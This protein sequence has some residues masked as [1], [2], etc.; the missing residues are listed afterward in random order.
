MQQTNPDLQERTSAF[1]LSPPSNGTETKQE[2]KS[3]VDGCYGGCLAML[4]IVVTLIA[5]FWVLIPLLDRFGISVMAGGTYS[6]VHAIITIVLVVVA[7]VYAYL[8]WKQ[9]TIIRRTVFAILYIGAFLLGWTV[10]ALAMQD[11]GVAFLLLFFVGILLANGALLWSNA[12]VKQCISML[13]RTLGAYIP[14]ILLFCLMFALIPFTSLSEYGVV[15]LSPL[16]LFLVGLCITLYL[17]C[18]AGIKLSRFF[19]STEGKGMAVLLFSAS[20]IF[21]LCVLFFVLF[22]ISWAFAAG[23]SYE[24]KM[25][26]RDDYE[27]QDRLFAIPVQSPIFQNHWS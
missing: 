8:F 13:L 14:L 22:L 5:S 2:E 6:I 24:R 10:L 11:Y 23:T 9:S 27:L 4:A 26:F 25:N 12:T 17:L 7:S 20:S 21:T 1:Y 19:S 15:A 18:L 3:R 16:L